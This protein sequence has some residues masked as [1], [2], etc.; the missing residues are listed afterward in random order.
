MKSLDTKPVVAAAMA[1]A[2][3]APPLL[4]QSPPSIVVSSAVSVNVVNIE[5]FVTGADG[6][7]VHGLQASDFELFEDGKP[8]AITNFSAA[9]EGEEV[10]GETAPAGEQPLLLVFFVDGLNMTP[11]Q[12]KAVFAKADAMLTGVLGVPGTKVMIVSGGLSVIVRQG[13]T[14]EPQPLL[15][16]L[17]VAQGATGE[18]A[19][20]ATQDVFLESMIDTPFGG[21]ADFAAADKE[22]LQRTMR[23]VAQQQ[24]E[25][26]KAE[27]Q[28]ITTFIASLGGLP[29]RKAM[30]YVGGP[31]PI[32]PG[33]TLLH[34]AVDDIG[35][36][37]AS[38]EA[39]RFDISPLLRK[40]ADRANAAGVTIYGV[41]AGG[42]ARRG[43]PTAMQRHLDSRPG[44]EA[45]AQVSAESAMQ[46]LAWTT[47]GCAFTNLIDPSG[48][49]EP[50]LLDFR[51]YYS[52]GF[53]AP[54]RADGSSHQI[55]VKM[56]R[57]GMAVRAR[58]TFLDLNQDDRMADRTLAAL[59]FDVAENPLGLQA[60][61]K[62]EEASKDKK[63]IVA[64][65][66]AIPLG[67]LVFAPT[68]VAH[69]S[70]LALWLAASDN[71]GH[72]IQSAKLKFPVSVP[73]DRLLTA[74]TQSAGY[75]FRVPMKEGP[76]KFSVTVRDE[77]ASQ[78]STVVTALEAVAVP[79]PG[80]PN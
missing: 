7:P 54:Y 31:I 38:L 1:F 18:G 66:V 5:A 65:T 58:S 41:D 76:C 51:S 16:A 78:A 19:G 2:A 6:R 59:L 55:K 26:G 47:G 56:K 33:E 72:V 48:A 29:G 60:L 9:G 22:A 36:A 46:F 32:R 63:Q 27:V 45:A 42:N 50:L 12:C 39:T 11:P 77:F 23:D 53:A 75:T 79:T 35:D 8:V 57:P 68:G 70:D 25:R 17:K 73:N 67:G 34:R 64:V 62:A 28:N 10:A 14:S 43:G 3:L 4:A 24:Y 20:A 69:Q 21:R 71:F 52:L 61:A 49:F 44:L 15:Q 37:S 30:I 40:L 13:F 80:V 74:L